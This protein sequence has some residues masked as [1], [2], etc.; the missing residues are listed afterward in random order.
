MGGVYGSNLI[1]HAL[2]LG[3]ACQLDLMYLHGTAAM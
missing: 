1:K 2:A 3:N